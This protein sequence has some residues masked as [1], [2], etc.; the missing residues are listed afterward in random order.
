MTISNK[1]IRTNSSNT[2][3]Q[4]SSSSDSPWSESEQQKSLELELDDKIDHKSAKYVPLKPLEE[5]PDSS[6]GEASQAKLLESE[7]EGKGYQ[8]ITK[9]SNAQSESMNPKEPA[10]NKINGETLNDAI[11][12]KNIGLVNHQWTEIVVNDDEECEAISTD[13]VK[14]A[15]IQ[16]TEREKHNPL[17][18]YTEKYIRVKHK[19]YVPVEVCKDR[20]GRMIYTPLRS[21]NK[22]KLSLGVELRTLRPPD[23]MDKSTNEKY[24]TSLPST[25]DKPSGSSFGE[26]YRRQFTDKTPGDELKEVEYPV[27]KRCSKK[28]NFPDTKIKI[29][30]EIIGRD[31][32]RDRALDSQHRLYKSNMT[33]QEILNLINEE[34]KLDAEQQIN[35]VDI[36]EQATKIEY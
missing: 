14:R 28:I 16:L 2:P 23:N 33:K 29:D 1:D 10:T 19:T 21:V 30:I 34:I 20:N 3:E 17:Y 15:I 25:H 12:F 7:R 32:N 36:I 24:S 11:K 35:V 13:E 22:P 27:C 6:W 18:N 8:Q 4:H 26:E 5:S 31:G 9:G